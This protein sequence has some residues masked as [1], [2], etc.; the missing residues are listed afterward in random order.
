MLPNNNAGYTISV[1]QNRAQLLRRLA[2]RITETTAQTPLPAN[3]AKD[4]LSEVAGFQTVV[5]SALSIG[6]LN[7]VAV[8]FF[9]SPTLDYSTEIQAVADAAFTAGSSIYTALP[10]TNQAGQDWLLLEA[11]DVVNKVFVERAFPSVPQGTLDDLNALIAL[12]P[13]DL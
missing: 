4:F 7:A 3:I 6:N 1:C 11:F 12:I 5:T 2:V 8:N 13:A 10:K 9:A